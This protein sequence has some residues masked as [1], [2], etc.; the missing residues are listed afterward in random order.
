MNLL[1]RKERTSAN[2]MHVDIFENQKCSSN[3]RLEYVNHKC[4]E[5]AE[6]MRLEGNVHFRNKMWTKAMIC[7]NDSLRFA[8]IRSE[9]AALAYANR[10]SSFLHLKMYN[11]CLADIELAIFANYPAHLMPKMQRKRKECLNL[12]KTG[13]R[14]EEIIP[15]LSYKPDENFPGMANLL[16]ISYNERYVPISCTSM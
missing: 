5:A 12:L 15:E 1:W 8:E 9:N 4:D 14:L 11:K 2:E 6:A 3:Q 7:Y 13:D 10:A 16:E